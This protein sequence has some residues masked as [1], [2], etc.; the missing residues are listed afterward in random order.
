MTNP[1][2]ISI[3]IP[4]HNEAANL[5]ALHA[6][7]TVTTRSCPEEFEFIYVDDGSTDDT[8]LIAKTLRRGHVNVRLV[9]LTRN[10]GKE[11]ATTAGL[12]AA[13]GEA[14]ITI[15]ADLQHPPALIPALIA[16]WR[17]GSEVVVGVRR[18]GGRHAP[19]LKRAGSSAFYRIIN[20]MSQV[21]IRAG[22]TDYRL[23]DRAVIHEFNR[24]TERGRITR[25]LIDWLGFRRA[26]VEFT[27]AK[28]HAGTAAYSYRK[29]FGLATTSIV[30]M[31]FFPLR[32]AG[33]LGV[34]ITLTSGPLGLF[35]LVEKYFMHDPLGLNITGTATLAVVLLFLC[36]IILMC[37]GLIA[38]YIATIHTEVMNRPLYVVRTERPSELERKL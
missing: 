1:T 31:S 37:L 9:Q 34:I 19:V 10:F 23:L 25:G 38:L 2:L 14:A 24:F 35:I 12:Q 18:T 13:T 5:E 15:D 26:F 33:Y 8:V 7:L 21:Q 4:C 28:R 20:T 29:L 32:L 6:A 11:I 3:I 27:P 36:G 22:A 17:E 16:A 30:S